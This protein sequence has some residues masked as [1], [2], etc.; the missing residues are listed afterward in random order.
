MIDALIIIGLVVA[1]VAIQGVIAWRA[2]NYRP[3]GAAD[4]GPIVRLGIAR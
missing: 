4:R 1:A 3:T 2:D